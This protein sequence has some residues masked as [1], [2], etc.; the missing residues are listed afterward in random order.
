[1]EDLGLERETQTGRTSFVINLLCRDCGIALLQAE[2]LRTN[3]QIKFR[4]TL[5]AVQS[6]H[7]FLVHF[8]HLRSTRA[9]VNDEDAFGF[10]DVDE[11]GGAG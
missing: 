5:R 7:F 1:V 3:N 11:E 6:V 9:T 2:I 4:S 10:E 8:S